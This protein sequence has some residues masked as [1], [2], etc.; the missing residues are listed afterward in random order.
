M[1]IDHEEREWRSANR[2]QMLLRPPSYD[3]ATGSSSAWNS[4]RHR[5]RANARWRSI[6]GIGLDD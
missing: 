1:E 2:R 4:E 5:R 3:I 6:T